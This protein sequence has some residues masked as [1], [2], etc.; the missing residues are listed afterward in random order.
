[1]KPSKIKEVMD[2]TYAAVMAGER[3][4][5]LFVSP[6]GIGKSE[7]VQQWCKENNLP[8]L[9]VRLAYLDAPDLIGYPIV[10]EVNGRQRMSHA[11]PDMWPDEGPV[12]VFLDEPNRGATA[13]MNAVMQML[14]DKKIH[15]YTFPENTIFVAAINPEDEHHDV[16]HMDSALRNRFTVYDVDYNK[17]DFIAFMK[18]AKWHKDVINFVESG[19]F[20]YK[21]PEDV[22]Q[23]AGNI[24][25]S[26]RSFSKANAALQSGFNMTKELE[27]ETWKAV[28]G[29]N[30][31]NAFYEFRNEETPVTYSDLVNDLPKALAKLE[32]YA[33]PKNNKNGHLSITC[34]ELVE[35]AEMVTND[36][37]TQVCLV[38][39]ADLFP[40]LIIRIE[41]ATNRYNLIDTLLKGNKELSKKIGSG[42]R[43]Q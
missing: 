12:V 39:P 16:N 13:V 19:A 4:I 27:R 20:E 7:I 23:T 22:G 15:Q 3:F 14:T 25:V 1:M 6:P 36:L 37:L 29:T 43:K 31:G 11:T 33:D 35:N 21:R 40:N 10:R 41:K 17:K 26:P 8:M 5:P 38:L 18:A 9:D 32:K 24:Y 30:M 42:L 28:L 2:L 34:S